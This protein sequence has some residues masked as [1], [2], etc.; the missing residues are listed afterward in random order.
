MILH[1][2][3]VDERDG[4]LTL[5]VEKYLRVARFR[6]SSGELEKALA[7]F[8]DDL[9]EV[10][11]HNELSSPEKL[12][13][14]QSIKRSARQW[15]KE[16]L[17]LGYTLSEVVHGYGALSQAITQYA[18]ENG[19]SSIPAEDFS[20][21]SLCLD[22]AIAEAVTEFDRRQREVAGQEEVQRLGF[23]AHELRNSLSNAAIAHRLM[24]SGIVGVRGNTAQLLDDAHKRMG[25]IID[26]SLAE[27]R[28][29]GEVTVECVRS[30]VNQLIGEVE[31]TA[32]FEANAKGIHLQSEI[33]AELEVFADRHLVV[34]AIANLVQNA[35]KFTSRGGTVWIRG[36]ANDGHAV[37]EVE[38]QCGGLPPG[39]LEDL[40]Q[41]FSQKSDDRTGIGLGLTIARR[42]I[43]L[44]GGEV[45]A[46]DLPGRGCV[47]A[48]KL[49][50]V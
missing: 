37:I 17:R 2:L 40:F 8:Y 47:F 24:K 35:I 7:H 34:S 1:Q 26:R 36:K 14:S 10:M 27:V 25:D 30:Y 19:G 3:L 9:I 44:N 23:L 31:I 28:L 13:A 49:P 12:E 45:S 6:V 46:R 11:R 39:K 43:S 32:A 20:R 48:I 42:A 5:C 4:I 50:R 18:F 29:R 21:L 16:S 41:P 38:D 33:D 15:G 22:T